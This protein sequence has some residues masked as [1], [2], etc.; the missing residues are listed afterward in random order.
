M[1]AMFSS[2]FQWMFP[3]TLENIQKA[4]QEKLQQEQKEHYQ[5]QLLQELIQNT[6][7]L[8]KDFSNISRQQHH[9]PAPAPAQ[10]SIVHQ[11]PAVVDQVIPGLIHVTKENKRLLE[12]VQMLVQNIE[13]RL[14][15][16]LSSGPD[17]LRHL[18]QFADGSQLILTPQMASGLGF[19]IQEG[20]QS[21]GHAK[22]SADTRRGQMH[23]LQTAACA[24]NHRYGLDPECQDG[25]GFLAFYLPSVRQQVQRANPELN[26]DQ[27]CPV[28][29]WAQQAIASAVPRGT[30]WQPVLE[31]I[32]QHMLGQLSDDQMYA[33]MAIADQADGQ[34]ANGDQAD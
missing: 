16:N 10:A 33:A 19:L 11:H 26:L 6:K 7:E 28:P 14:S 9:Q 18:G 25:Q 23:A 4:Q 5:E 13:A 17:Y 31:P 32:T 34:T 20:I 3:K 2:C 12:M 21:Y 30:D 8:Q 1:T 27:L 29:V 22:A 15:Q 24:N